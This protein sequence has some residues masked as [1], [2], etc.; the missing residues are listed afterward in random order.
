[1]IRLKELLNPLR[2][3]ILSFQYISHRVLRWTLAPLGLLI[4]LLC[5]ALVAAVNGM[6]NFYSIY[7]WF[8]WGQAAF[9]LVAALG[10]V[11]EQRKM[12][13]KLLYIPYYFFIMNLAVYLG[14]VRYLKK[15]QSVNWERAKRG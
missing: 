2:F 4:M 10:W 14:F 11:L 1:M 6:L 5:S 9:Y 8:F 12:S 7:T 13:V 3:G 15:Q